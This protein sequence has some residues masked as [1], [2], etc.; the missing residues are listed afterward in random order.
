M[1]DNASSTLSV[2]TSLVA[3]RDVSL[4]GT[5]VAGARHGMPAAL[6]TRIAVLFQSPRAAADPRLSLADLIAEPSAPPAPPATTPA[7]APQD[8]PTW[9]ASPRPYA[10]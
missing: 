2:C 1:A 5:P 9:S 10:S 6:R 4:D 7:V 8:S 3:R